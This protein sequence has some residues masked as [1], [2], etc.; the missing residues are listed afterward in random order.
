MTVLPRVGLVGAGA[1]GAGI[2]G[3]LIAHGVKVRTL[4]E[5]RGAA[6]VARAREADMQAATEIELVECDF[7]LSVLPSD[8][9]LSFAKTLA[10]ALTAAAHKP[11]F[12]E[13]N[14]LAPSTLTAIVDTIEP[15]G[16]PFVDGCIIGPIPTPNGAGP[17]IYVSG[18]HATRALTLSEFGLDIRHLSDRIGDASA[19]KLC[20]SGIAKGALVLADRMTGLAETLGVGDA[21]A[22]ILREAPISIGEPT[23]ARRATIDSKAPRWASELHEIQTLAAAQDPRAT[24]FEE[25]ARYLDGISKRAR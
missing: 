14:A 22:T 16:V 8:A 21:L 24:I 6:T 15:L 12:V 4:L 3:R 2:A 18:P 23:L 17:A 25:L 1:M 10:P 7:V 11:I 5:G 20:H 19:L 9:A 13:C